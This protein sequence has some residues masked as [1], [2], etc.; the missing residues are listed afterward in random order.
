MAEVTADELYDLVIAMFGVRAGSEGQAPTSAVGVIKDQ[1]GVYVVVQGR[2]FDSYEELS[3]TWEEH[4]GEDLPEDEI[5]DARNLL[6][7]ARKKGEWTGYHAEMMIVGAMISANAWNHLNW[8][9]VKAQ[10]AANGG[11]V[12]CANAPCCL[13]CGSALDDLGIEYHGVK[14][15]ASN[16]AWWNP[17][18]DLRAAHGS[19]EFMKL[20]PN[21]V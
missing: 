10:I 14:G 20:I 12:I 5:I 21:K 2:P 11:A 8:A 7:T 1:A 9:G 13:H 17:V 15:V 19:G 16:T 4:F 3:E 18:N 6:V